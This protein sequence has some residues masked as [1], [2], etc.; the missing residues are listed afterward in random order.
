MTRLV[1]PLVIG[2][3][4]SAIGFFV[5]LGS[6][7]GGTIELAWVGL[8]LLVGVGPAFCLAGCVLYALRPPTRQEIAAQKSWDCRT[9]H[10]RPAG[11]LIFVVLVGALVVIGNW[12][13][14]YIPGINS[15]RRPVSGY[16]FGLLC[17]SLLS[18]RRIRDFV[19][20]TGEDPAPRKSGGAPEHGKKEDV[21]GNQAEP[22]AA[23]RPPGKQ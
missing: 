20:F 13:E 18:F 22:D 5:L 4:M 3:C 15:G 6:M 2:I 8:A 7:S 19:F 9:W 23:A 17:L 21:Q 10:F 16:F 14:Q 11:L 12:A 1:L